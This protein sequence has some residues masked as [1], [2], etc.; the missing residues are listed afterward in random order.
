MPKVTKALFAG[1]ERATCAMTE[2]GL[3]P[4]HETFPKKYFEVSPS[5]AMGAAS[6]NTPPFCTSLC[7]LDNCL[8]SAADGPPLP[9]TRAKP[10]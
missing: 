10:H 6:P 9:P 3:E 1:D 8:Q 2:A 7:P 5:H 4:A